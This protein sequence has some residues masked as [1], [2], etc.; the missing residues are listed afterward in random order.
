MTQSTKASRL[1]RNEIEQKL[2]AAK[3]W[4]RQQA[5]QAPSAEEEVME[6][7]AE[8]RCIRGN[9]V[10]LD[11]WREA[12]RKIA[13]TIPPN[14]T[15]PTPPDGEIDSCS[16]DGVLREFTLER[17]DNRPLRFQGYLVGFHEIDLDVPRGTAVLVFVTKS[18]KIVTSV[19]QWQRDA[20]RERERHDAAAHDTAEGALDWLIQDGGGCLGR[21][22]R[23]AWERACAT[24]P[25]LQGYNVEVVE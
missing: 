1:P 2:K 14:V 21:V 9:S 16:L 25:P 7:A 4:R 10:V 5:E 13:Q 11:V 23:Q 8:Q 3:K 17:D 6:H 24:W 19:Y 15:V 22:S 12:K 18:G 20:K